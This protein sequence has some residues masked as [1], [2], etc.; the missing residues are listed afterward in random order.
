MVLRNT[1][2]ALGRDELVGSISP[3]HGY[4]T[5][6]GAADGSTVIDARLIGSNDFITGKSILIMNGPAILELSEATAFDP[7][8]GQITIGP[9]FSAQITAGVLYRVLNFVSGLWLSTLLGTNSGA[10][11]YLGYCPAGMVA[12]TNNIFCS[13]L[14]GLGDNTF[15]RG[16]QM[17]VLRNANS[18]GNVPEMEMRDITNY[19]SALGQF[20]TSAFSANV[21]E[22]DTVLIIHNSL[23]AQISA[24]GIAD[25]GSGVALVRDAA[26]TEGDDWWNGQTVM[27]LSGAARGQKRPIADFIAA[28]DDIVPSPDFDAAVAAGDRYVILA[29]YN[30]IVPRVADGAANYLTSDVVGNK[31]DTALYAAT[32]TA[33]L[34]RYLKAVLHADIIASGALTFSS[35][36][37]PA[38]NTRPEAA[39]FFNGCLLMPVAGACAFE[40]K[41]IIDFT[42]G[43]GVFTIDGFN[44]FSAAT[45]AV[46]YVIIRH[47]TNNDL[48]Q[49]IRGGAESLESLD[50]ELDA[51]LD[52]ARSPDSGTTLVTN[53]EDTLYEENAANPFEFGGGFIDL[54]NMLAGDTIRIRVYAI[55]AAGGLYR[56]MSDD[57]VNTYA[58]VQSPRLKRIDGFY[59]QYG[60]KVTAERTAGADVSVP[61]E[62]FDAKRSI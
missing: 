11:A 7:V 25:A 45:G 21:E 49:S 42:A 39:D 34:M 10:L 14:V 8:T 19:G 29:H 3:H 40:P 9:P 28:T 60:V 4:A 35:A 20:A 23:A 31:A 52:L 12:S 5:N 36:T 46:A 22:N 32:A 26:R 37:A 38:D 18:P 24:Y 43:T 61:H 2:H 51:M 62:W 47:Q 59:N 53:A 54:G 48:L 56:Q 1:A 15:V 41:L 50:D 30:P 33:S 27:M 16:Y 13:N 58:G 6:A 17:I 44:P 57:V 55:I